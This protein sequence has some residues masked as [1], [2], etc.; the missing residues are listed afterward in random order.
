LWNAISWACNVSLFFTLI[1][2]I[3]MFIQDRIKK[4]Y[5]DDGID[6]D[7]IENDEDEF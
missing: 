6:D 1:L 5:G 2:F 4:S 3:T 7:K